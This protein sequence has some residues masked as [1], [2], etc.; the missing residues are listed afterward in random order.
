MGFIYNKKDSF[1]NAI[2]KWKASTDKQRAHDL[3]RPQH[4]KY[5]FAQITDMHIPGELEF[6]HRL[7]DL[8]SPQDTVGNITHILSALS[9]E[10]SHRYRSARQLYSNILK[11]AFAGFHFLEVDHVIIS[12]DIAHCGLPPE[13]LEMQG[14]LKKTGW[15]KPELLTIV[16]G[17][18]DRFNLYERFPGAPMENFFDVVSS[19]KPRLK[20]LPEGIALLEFDSNNDR[21]EDR[22]FAEQ[23]LPNSVGR[24]YDEEIEWVAK[25]KEKVKGMRVLT[26]L[27]H[28]VSSDWYGL[29]PEQIGG[30]MQPVYRGDELLEQVRI[31]DTHSPVLH[32][33]KHQCMPIDYMYLG[34]PVSC[35]GGFAD[36][37]TITIV[38]VDIN[39]EISFTHAAVRASPRAFV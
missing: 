26:V 14:I 9:N 5:R 39:D 29:D 23:W 11:K 25:Q 18:H 2:F 20:I 22:D 15:W 32:G 4:I 12:G 33:H 36:T 7:R 3:R 30:F 38:D 8:M 19:R 1:P 16:P 28:H 34:H 37:L 13:F 6:M 35:P 10:L 17:N 21:E 31:L 24:F 27:H